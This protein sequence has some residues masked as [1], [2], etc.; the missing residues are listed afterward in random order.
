[1][2]SGIFLILFYSFFLFSFTS[3]SSFFT[4]FSLEFMGTV[5]VIYDK[6]KQ[7][8]KMSFMLHFLFGL[9]NSLSPWAQYSLLWHF[10]FFYHYSVNFCI[11]LP[12]LNHHHLKK[13]NRS[14]KICYF[15][16]KCENKYRIVSETLGV[17]WRIY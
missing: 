4:S 13:I 11:L 17:R 9:L 7:Q 14:T 12:S 6:K 16:T 1:M 8:Q 10:F 2:S 3:I 15:Q 5:C